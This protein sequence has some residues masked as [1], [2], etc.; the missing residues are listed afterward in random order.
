[1]IGAAAGLG[2]LLVTGADAGVR[3]ELGNINYSDV[4]P[5]SLNSPAPKPSMRLG[6]MSLPTNI[7]VVLKLQLPAV[8]NS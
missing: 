3:H 1:M 8:K 7:P 4:N 2:A 6:E 5:Y